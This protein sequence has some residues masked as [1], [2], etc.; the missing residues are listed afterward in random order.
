MLVP[1]YY[2]LRFIAYSLYHGCRWPGV[3]KDQGISSEDVELFY[4]NIITAN[5]R[6]VLLS[7]HLIWYVA[8]IYS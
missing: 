5:G 3:A 4:G 6:Y 2:V 7:N 1:V 8:P